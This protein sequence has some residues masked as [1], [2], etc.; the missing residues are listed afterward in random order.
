MN[1]PPLVASTFDAL[2]NGGPSAAFAYAFAI[3]F[4]FGAGMLSAAALF[5]LLPNPLNP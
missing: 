4:G 1:L 5:N 3:G 2:S